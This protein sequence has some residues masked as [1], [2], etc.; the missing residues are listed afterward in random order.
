MND[1][2]SQ[3]TKIGRDA[4]NRA[5]AIAESHPL[6][7]KTKDAVYTA[8]GLGVLSTKRASVAL[9]KAQSPADVKDVSDTVKKTVTDVVA[10]L[11]RQS[12]WLD[13][14]LNK[15]AKSIDE[16]MA[17]IEQHLPGAVRELAARARTLTE[18]LSQRGPS[19]PKTKATSAPKRS[20]KSPKSKGE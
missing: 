3:A 20:S 7:K 5:R 2:T 14:Q 19:E 1:L 10:T 6:A 9:K 13:D 17:P 16:A 8:V 18:K 4:A 12:A 11:K 15:T